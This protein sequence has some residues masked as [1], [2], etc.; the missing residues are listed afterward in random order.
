MGVPCLKLLRRCVAPLVAVVVLVPG[1][2]AATASENCSVAAFPPAYPVSI[3]AWPPAC[4]RPYS[5][6]GAF[7]LPLPAGVPPPGP[8]ELDASSPAVLASQQNPPATE[9]PDPEPHPSPLQIDDWG[10]I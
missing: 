8:G 1:P 7:N 10:M 5:D 6:T 2:A 3:G 4:W 9:R